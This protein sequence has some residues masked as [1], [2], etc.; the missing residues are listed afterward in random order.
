[1]KLVNK[2][3][4]KIFFLLILFPSVIIFSQSAT[5]SFNLAMNAFRNGEYSKALS[6]FNK[7]NKLD[8]VEN[9]IYSSA[10]Y[11]SSE[12]YIALDEPEG[13][14]Q[15]LTN[16]IDNYR[17]SGFRSL[18]LYKLGSLYFDLGEYNQAR[19]KLILLQSEYPYSEYKGSAYF[20]IGDSFAKQKKYDDAISFLKD[21]LSS[22]F[23]NNFN[24]YTTYSL[25]NVYEEKQ[26]YRNAVKYYDQMLGF[27]KKSIL[28]PFAQLRIGIC[29][30]N[31]KEYESAVLE[32]TDPLIDELPGEK[33]NEATYIL[34][35]TY[36]RLNDFD[37]AAATYK[38]LL[39]RNIDNHMK[40]QIT[41]G[42]AWVN[43]Q[44]K[45]YE[46]AYKIFSNLAKVQNDSIA[47][48]S[49]FWSAECKRYNNEITAATKIY[50]E[51]LEKY[52]ENSLAAK[53]KLSLGIVKYNKNNL[54][55]SEETI[56]A[57]LKSADP[58]TRGKAFILLGE[59]NL[60]K[61]KFKT[62]QQYFNRGL[63]IYSLPEKLKNRGYLGLG[64]SEF[65]MNKFN[66]AISALGKIHRDLIT[67]ERSKADFYLAE[68]YSALGKYSK[69]VQFYNRIKTTDDL[70][71]RQ[72]LYG[73]A[74]A[75]FNK[76]D[77]PNAA[78]YFRKYVNKYKKSAEYLDAKQRLA[79]CY[80][81]TKDFQ[82]ASGVFYDLIY[83]DKV[84]AKN[85]KAYYQYGQALFKAGESSKALEVFT[86]LQIKFP[87]SKYNDESQYLV[88]WIH[89]QQGDFNE[90]IIAYRKIFE[91]YPDSKLLP[92]ALYSVGD[93]Y[94]NLGKYNKAI[95]T[96][97][98]VIN[99]FP[100]SN[101]VFDAVNGILY[102]YE[103]QD[104]IKEAENFIS[105]F[106]DSHTN[107][108]F[109]DKIYFK[110]GDLY[111]SVNDYKMAVRNYKNFLN[112][113][114]NSSLVPKAYYWLGKS[115]ANLGNKDEAL[116]YFGTVIK[117][118][119]KSEIGVASVLEAGKIYNEKKDYNSEIAL[120]D[121]TIEIIKNI[122]GS[123]EV[124]FMKAKALLNNNNFPEAYATFMQIKELF[125][126]SIF[127]DKSSVEL[128]IFE[129]ARKNYD[130]SQ[131][132]FRTIAE[133]RKDDIGAEAQYYYGVS[134]FE[135]DKV[136]DAITAFVRVR[137]VYSA[138]DEWYTKSLLKLGDCYVKLGEK[139][140]AKQ[141][142]SAVLKRHPSDDY[143]KEA[144]TKIKEL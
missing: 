72:T 77:F 66:E 121:S 101:N 139:R 71:R 117:Q 33:Q 87:G 118:Y 49:L 80:L 8:Y 90:A 107:A 28:A 130:K 6:L 31:L 37:K 62:A 127:A 119:L 59:I 141:M 17:Y 131:D 129:L 89:F 94:F 142:Y 36:Y 55:A 10:K 47:V 15:E 38:A 102:C 45:N 48:N 44:N 108:D 78:F 85:S 63:E 24:D 21:A 79:S 138:Y 29:Y 61:K 114:P 69:A 39:G 9:E 86:Q 53:A 40:N 115:S 43:F 73:K 112:R 35:N 92:T 23:N 56:I 57:S 96:Y 19:S 144:K 98:K 26:D 126:G 76:K 100:N 82:K 140:N 137:S 124:Y 14:I 52:P 111:Y 51:F 95:G 42:L 105:K 41:Y 97:S 83:K 74:Y 46:K 103:V 133:Q 81:G 143:G 128:G 64:I 20:L 106:I 12:C 75:Y 109:N 1:L 54:K 116:T 18:A 134:F 7:L 99:Q 120:Y 13:A 113:F 123:S 125:P 68:S 136:E 132:Y 122:K 34:A 88:G 30:F 16:L 70:L 4:N 25:A 65:Y 32:L 135:Q 11:Y 3:F 27:Y 91:A 22:K 2:L 67:S 58:H 110:K 60:D 93:S 5:D 50:N 84:F 104:K